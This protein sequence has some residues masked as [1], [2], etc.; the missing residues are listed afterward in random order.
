MM[1]GIRERI[2]KTNDQRIKMALT[3]FN[4][5]KN[6]T[7]RV[8]LELRSTVAATMIEMLQTS[9]IAEDTDL[10]EVINEGIDSVCEDVKTQYGITDFRNHLKGIVKQTQ[11]QVERVN[12]GEDILKSLNLNNINLN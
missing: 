12:A 2:E 8:D 1:N 4:I 11:E 10:I 9:M 6:A 7:G 3:L 5:M